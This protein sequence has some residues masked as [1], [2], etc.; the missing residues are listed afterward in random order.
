MAN[1]MESP[2]IRCSQCGHV[3]YDVFSRYRGIGPVCRRHLEGDPPRF[4]RRRRG[5]P[6]EGQGILMLVFQGTL[7]FGAE[8]A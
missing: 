1:V 5:R 4:P 2:E 3:L 6:G 8:A 7:E